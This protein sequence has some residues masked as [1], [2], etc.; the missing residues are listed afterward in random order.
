M[1][2]GTVALPLPIPDSPLIGRLHADHYDRVSR[3]G[4]RDCAGRYIPAR[5]ADQIA[6]V[7]GLGRLLV[8]SILLAGATSLPEL[9]VNLAAVRLNLIDIA[10][11]DLFGSNLTNL[12][13]LAALDL[14][15]RSRGKMFSREAAAHALSGTLGVALAALAGLAIVTAGKFG[16]YE[17][18]GLEPWS[19]AIL[20]A[21][22]LG[23]RLV[24][25]DQRISA[26]A[27]SERI[28]KLAEHE[29]ISVGRSRASRL[30]TPIIQF[31]LAAVVVLLT[32][33]RFADVSGRLAEATGLGESFVGTTFVALSTSLPELV[34][35][36]AAL[37]IGAFDLVVGNVF[38]SN[39]FNMLLLVPLDAVKAGP[40]FAAASPVHAVTCL[41]VIVA[42]AVAVLGQLYRVEKRWPIIEPDAWLMLLILSIGLLLVYRL[43]T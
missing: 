5:A 26:R 16:S 30:R 42:T 13:I 11:G 23:M 41:A 36:L 37:R 32:G 31:A 1:L 19:W 9:S 43:S 18:L 14:A 10:V 35:S 33:P 12:L 39:A 21:Y 40:L 28:T 20:V 8:G 22:L 25:L 2:N 29:T 38:G 24:F 4:S 3:V 34:A 27:A 15:Q 17:V 6:E 7:T